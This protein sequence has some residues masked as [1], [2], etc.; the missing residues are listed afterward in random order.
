MSEQRP[1][2]QDSPGSQGSPRGDWRTD[3]NEWRQAGRE[4][5][6]EWRRNDPLRGLFPG[7]VLVLLGI[8]LFLWTQGILDGGVW[9]QY[10]LIGLGGIFLLDGLIHYWHP[11]YHSRGAGRFIPGIILVLVG[12]AILVGFSEWWPL[13]LVGVGVAILLGMLFRNR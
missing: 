8:L 5:R 9:W 12:T 7:L 10:F 3:R 6:H 13:I 11:A 1:D 2:N 4:W